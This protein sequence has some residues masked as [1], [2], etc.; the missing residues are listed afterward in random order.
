[1]SPESCDQIPDVTFDEAV[2]A[3]EAL[4]SE[5]VVVA[6]SVWGTDDGA[7]SLMDA[8]GVLRRMESDDG[9][10]EWLER[11]DLVG[12]EAVVFLVGPA[13]DHSFSLWRSRFVSASVDDL[14]GIAIRTR[15]GALR[16]RRN[17]QSID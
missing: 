6:V 3:L 17:R 16:V 1:M 9:I 2:E 8:D 4:A 11:Q 14:N 12:E 5:G 7:F 15:D 13:S 10:S